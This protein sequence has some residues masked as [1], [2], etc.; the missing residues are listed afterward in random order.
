MC[1][2][3]FKKWGGC[4]ITQK[5]YCFV[6]DSGTLHRN[7]KSGYFVYAGYVFKS[8][9]EMYDAKRK[10][11]NAHKKISKCILPKGEMKACILSN[12][13][14]RA[15]YK[16]LE[17]YETFSVGIHIVHVYGSILDNKKAICRYKDYVLKRIIKAKIFD[18][19]R[20]Q[21]ISQD[22]DTYITIYIDEQLTSTNG[23]YSF[24]E[25]VLEEFRH[26][27]INYNYGS[28]HPPVFRCKLNIDVHYCD[29]KSNYLIQ[30][31]DILANKIWHFYCSGNKQNIYS[32]QKH[33]ALTLP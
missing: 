19:I 5:L 13:H 26:G 29:S 28:V 31:S 20:K 18:L 11:I 27:I 9:E 7:E 24:K 30:A 14:K 16:I 3:L 33:K 12:T 15:L 17:K 23:F 10:Y 8:K 32:M 1:L 21:I 4:E 2:I 22:A 6:D 25:S